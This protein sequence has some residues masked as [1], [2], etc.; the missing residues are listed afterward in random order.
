M[1]PGG[2]VVQ[3]EVGRGREARTMHTGLKG[4]AVGREKGNVLERDR[5]WG[6][7]KVEELADQEGR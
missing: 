2:S 7:A 3:A 4:G 5:A 1:A 6:R